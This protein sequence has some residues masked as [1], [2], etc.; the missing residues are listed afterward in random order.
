MPRRVYRPSGPAPSK[1]RDRLDYDRNRRDR[2]A[3]RFYQSAPWRNLRRLKLA[4]DPL[5]EPCREKARYVPAKQVHHRKPRRTH[6][7]LALDIDNLQ[8]VCIPCHN[9]LEPR[10]KPN[11]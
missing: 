11:A 7:D 10:G 3:A 9:R 8:S 1:A 2:E 5:C 4:Q 6:P